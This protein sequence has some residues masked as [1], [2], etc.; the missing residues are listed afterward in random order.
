MRRF[1]SGLTILAVLTWAGLALADKGGHGEGHGGHG[2][3]DE[4]GWKGGDWDDNWKNWNHG[5]HYGWYKNGMPYAY[6]PYYNGPGYMQGWNWGGGYYGGPRYL[7]SPMNGNPW[8]GYYYNAPYYQN[9]LG[10]RPAWPYYW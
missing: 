1:L 3:H 7:G 5:N 6:Y 10:Y 4:H 8:S 9:W 2:D